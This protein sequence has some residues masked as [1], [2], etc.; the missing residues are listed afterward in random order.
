MKIK[1]LFLNFKFSQMPDVPG[2]SWVK[3]CLSAKDVVY[4]GVRDV[5]PGEE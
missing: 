1:M 4:I 5:D 2:F 3:P